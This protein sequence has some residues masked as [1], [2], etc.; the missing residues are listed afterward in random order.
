MEEVTNTLF[1]SGGVS[2]FS[3]GHESVQH[4]CVVSH[5]C[6]FR[7]GGA[8]TGK[9]ATHC[10]N[11][12]TQSGKVESKR[13][14]QLSRDQAIQH[15]A[16]WI[17]RWAAYYRKR[18]AGLSLPAIHRQERWQGLSGIQRSDFG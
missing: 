16:G 2:G 15:S 12:E 1:D 18:A 10:W 9:A 4:C 14:A 7:V 5:D 6:F 8:G 13:S 11:M 3:K 17:S